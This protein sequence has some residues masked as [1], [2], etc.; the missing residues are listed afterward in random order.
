VRR[1]PCNPPQG[2]KLLSDK[3]TLREPFVLS[4]DFQ[5]ALN[6]LDGTDQHIFVTGRAGTGKSTLLQLFRKT[7]KKKCIV[8]APTGVSA[9]NVKGQTIHSFFGFAPRILTS[10]DIEKRKNPKFF[11]SIE[12]IVIDEISMV[13]ADLLDN[14]DYALRLNREDPRPF[15]GVQMV[16]FGDLYQLPPVVASNYE[17]D[18]FRSIYS[19]PYFF[20][21]KVF[22]QGFELEYL[23]LTKVY[24]QEERMFISLLESIRSLDVD[25]E[26]LEALNERVSKSQASTDSHLTLTMRNQT[27]RRI[28]ASALDQISSPSFQYQAKI[29]GNFNPKLYPTD[30]MLKLKEG[31]QVMFIKNDPF[32]RFVNGTI[33][34]VKTLTKEKVWVAISG[35]EK[36]SVIDVEQ[37]EWEILRYKGTSGTASVDTEVIGSFRQYPLR[38]AWAITV[39]KSQGKTFDRVIIDLGFGA[40]EHG[41]MYVALS[42]CRTLDGIV[43]RKPIRYQDILVDERIVD[44]H[45]QMLRKYFLN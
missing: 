13:R 12:V 14:I 2:I 42:R 25:A 9:L 8:L 22:E 45:H 37:Q 6:L 5:A 20:S 38:L 39:H 27:A 15:G 40:F 23:E 41:Q 16:F 31:A 29:T 35:Q 3:L 1:A 10:K 32:R 36:Q 33:G 19:T 11:R 30:P 44:F 17:R 24:R 34:I 4:K 7:T 28:N 26:V 43:L 21:A 18:F